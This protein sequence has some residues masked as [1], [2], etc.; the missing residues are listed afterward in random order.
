MRKTISVF[1]G[2]L[3]CANVIAGENDFRCLKSLDTKNPIRL[4]FDFP[5]QDKKVGYVTYQKVSELIQV[6]NTNTKEIRRASGGRP[7]E[8]EAE[9]VEKFA[10]GEGGTYLVRSQAARIYDFKYIRKKDGK[11]FRFVEDLDAS[12][13]KGCQW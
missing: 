1:L 12:V 4:Q 10:S 13:G 6:K 2:I 7:S 8:F 11:V 3:A 9:W 5:A